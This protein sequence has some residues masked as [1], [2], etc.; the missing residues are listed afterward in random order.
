MKMLPTLISAGLLA[1]ALAPAGAQAPALPADVYPESRFRL[2]LP[3]RDDFD[4]A[5]KKV[6]DRIVDPARNSL[7][8]L[9]GP[10]GIRLASPR[11]ATSWRTPTIICDTKPASATG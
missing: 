6:F 4:D 1:L 7:V 10:A 9:Q 8:G 11:L 5:G 2:P 3:K